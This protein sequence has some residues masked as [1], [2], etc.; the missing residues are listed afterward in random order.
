M[1][2][3]NMDFPQLALVAFL[4][5]SLIQTFKPLY[6]KDKGWNKDALLALFVGIVLC[7]A[8]KVDLFVAVGLPISVPYVGATLTGVLAS[9]G[10]NF[11]HDILKFVEGK[12]DAPDFGTG[13]V[14]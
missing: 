14:G 2:L 6:D 13:P 9:R 7:V 1:N 11:V 4:I 3:T 5:E 12:S 10:S 8:T